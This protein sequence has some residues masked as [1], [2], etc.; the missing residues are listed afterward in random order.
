[1]KTPTALAIALLACTAQ[2][3]PLQ[4]DA[5]P[6]GQTA[7]GGACTGAPALLTWQ[8]ALQA[9]SQA[10]AALH[11]D[12]ADWRV[13]N[14]TE[15]ESTVDLAAPGASAF[16]SSTSYHPAPTG[17]WTVDFG[18]GASSPAHKTA[19]GA[20]RRCV[21]TARPFHHARAAIA[22]PA[23]PTRPTA[24]HGAGHGVGRRWHL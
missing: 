7:S 2:A 6:W 22:Q 17:A 1:M 15:L 24:A 8:Q 19:L 20:R 3:A 9:A 18:D 12:Q 11:Q 23:G 10:N 5:C 14:R 21:P 16:W 13:P 4:W